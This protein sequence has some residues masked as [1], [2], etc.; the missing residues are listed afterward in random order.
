MSRRV[1]MNASVAGETSSAYTWSPSISRTSGQSS[2]D[3]LLHPLGE[4]VEGVDLAP[5]LV[6]VLA[7]RVGRL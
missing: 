6:L 2:R 4:R 1:S 7:Q 5:A 3:S